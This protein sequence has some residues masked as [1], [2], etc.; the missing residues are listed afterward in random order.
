MLSIVREG[1]GERESK[2]KEEGQKGHFTGE[3]LSG[4]G[5][6]EETGRGR[7]RERDAVDL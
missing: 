7:E 1:A 2:R 3:V 5:G 6:L 4:G